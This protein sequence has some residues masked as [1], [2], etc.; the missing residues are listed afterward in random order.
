MLKKPEAVFVEK[1]DDKSSLVFV[2]SRLTKDRRIPL[3][4]K[5]IIDVTDPPHCSQTALCVRKRGYLRPS[6]ESRQRRIGRFLRS[7]AERDNAP[8]Y[9]AEDERRQ[10]NSARQL[11]NTNRKSFEC[12][13]IQRS[14]PQA[15]NRDSVH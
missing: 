5:L 6:F 15:D 13:G 1:T 9:Q 7:F 11:Q 10:D 4:V 8:N 3:H 14:S 2:F 12:V